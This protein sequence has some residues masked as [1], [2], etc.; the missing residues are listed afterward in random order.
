MLPETSDPRVL[1]ARRLIE[2]AGIAEVVWVPEPVADERFDQVVDH[3]LKRRSDKGLDRDGARALAQQ[4]LYFGAALV[5]LG[6]ADGSVAGAANP[7]AEVIRA[8]LYCLGTSDA[9]PLVSSMFLMVRDTTVYSFADCGAVPD[10]DAAQLATIAATTASSHHLLTGD[11]PRVAFL[12]FSTKGSADHPRVDKVRNAA[13][14]FRNQ[15]PSILSDGELQFDAASVP[16]IAATK[17]PESPLQGKA[18]VFIF[19]D[20][21]AGNAAYKI[22][23]RLGGFQAFGPL[24]QGLAAPCLDLSRGCDPTDIL[25]VTAIAAIFSAEAEQA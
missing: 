9:T 23:Q 18:N 3:I 4:P 20:L 22:A 21:D 14:A 6:E 13:E 16:E 17:A 12:S 15:H 8:G 7:T 1:E 19:P 24:I 10:P 2:E 25:N 5:A 11:D